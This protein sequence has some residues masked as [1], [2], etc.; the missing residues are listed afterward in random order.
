VY[1]P[2][3]KGESVMESWTIQSLPLSGAKGLPWSEAK[4]IMTAGA[5]TLEFPQTNRESGMANRKRALRPELAY[6]TSQCPRR[7]PGK[8]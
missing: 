6:L 3:A 2:G 1:H 4:D 5:R 8:A 7:E